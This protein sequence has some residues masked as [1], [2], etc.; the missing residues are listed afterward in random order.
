M[1]TGYTADVCDGKITEFRDFALQC[2]RAFGAL[3]TMR[4]ERL[5]APIPDEVKPSA[6]HADK[7]PF[8][9]ARLDGM[10]D[11]S[12]EDAERGAEGD[13]AANVASRAKRDRERQEQNDRLN[14]MLAGVE[15][16]TPP[17]AD[18]VEMKNFMCD[19]LTMSIDK[20][21]AQ[22]P[23]VKLSGPD[24]LAEQIVNALRE[25]EYHEAENAKEIERART[26]TEWLRQLRASLTKQAE[27]A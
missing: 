10:R 24:W 26:R 7:L 3:I 20:S 9:R 12:P 14:A 16:W 5:D 1:P 13:Y 22:E 2:A 23:I 4:D 25:V 8:L 6:Y 15:D 27:A 19:Q 17:T 21:Y 18:H 11:M